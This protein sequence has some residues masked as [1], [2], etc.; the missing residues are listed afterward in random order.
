VNPDFASTI[1]TNNWRVH[2]DQET[3]EMI[4]RAEYKKNQQ[5]DKVALFKVEQKAAKDNLEEAELYVH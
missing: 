1:T 2:N 3:L 5:K 4:Q